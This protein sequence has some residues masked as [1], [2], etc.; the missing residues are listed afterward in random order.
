MSEVVASEQI[1]EIIARWTDIPVHK[2]S[3]SEKERL[4]Q[5]ENEL[6]T[7]VVGQSDAVKAVSE[8]VLRSRAG[9]SRKDQPTG[10]FMFL[11]PT[12]VGKTELAKGSCAAHL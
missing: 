5:M 1:A 2:L 10:S 7:R 12:G 4:L 8:A 6:N 9:M 3:G 11:G